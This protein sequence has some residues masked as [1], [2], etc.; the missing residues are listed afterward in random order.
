[1]QAHN[2]FQD[3]IA[4]V[5][6]AQGYSE[7]V[8]TLLY[9][10]LMLDDSLPLELRTFMSRV[11]GV[12]QYLISES[13]ELPAKEP[14]ISST[15]L[16]STPKTMDEVT[17]MLSGIPLEHRGSALIAVQMTINYINSKE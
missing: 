8:Q 4:D 1:M 14:V 15:N 10:E 5:L 6:K 11:S 7:D 12:W 9:D 2:K 16:V 3:L 13:I 17:N